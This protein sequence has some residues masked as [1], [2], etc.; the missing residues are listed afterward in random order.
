VESFSTLKV[1]DNFFDSRQS[2][3]DKKV[4][5]E[6][7]F[8][9]KFVNDA[10]KQSRDSVHVGDGAKSKTIASRNSTYKIPEEYTEVVL[11]GDP[12]AIICQNIN[13]YMGGVSNIWKNSKS[14]GIELHNPNAGTDKKVDEKVNHNINL[15]ERRRGEKDFPRFN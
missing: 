7:I 6:E 5:H 13:N 3:R 1:D 9:T 4:E 11:K 10:N 2:E 15:D 12:V 14:L 8:R